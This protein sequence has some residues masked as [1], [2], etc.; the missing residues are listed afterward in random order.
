MNRVTLI[1]CAA[2]ALC[3]FYAWNVTGSLSD[4][5]KQLN[6]A[7][8]ANQQLRQKND[9][10]SELDRK[11]TEALKNAREENDRLNAA[12]T[13]GNKRVYVK[14]SCQ[15]STAA[16]VGN[17]TAAELDRESRQD[18]FRLRQQLIDVRQ[19]VLVLQDYVRDV[20]LK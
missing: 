12:V 1:L 20:C 4:A 19:Q 2:L 16:S 11:N 10:L 7:V 17:A 14:A 8:S 9:S 15:K 18:Y 5:K 3:G 13:A 6:E